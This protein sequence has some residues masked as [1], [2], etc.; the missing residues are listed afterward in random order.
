MKLMSKVIVLLCILSSTELVIAQTVNQGAWMIG[1]TAGFSSQKFDGV[2]ESQTIINITP[3][4]GY[5]IMDDLAIGARVNFLS[6]SFDGDTDSNF[7]FGPYARYY[8]TNPIFLQAGIDF[9]A[10]ALDLNSLLNDEGSSTLHF[11][12][13]YSWFLNNS[14]AIEPALYYD[15]Y[16]GDEDINDADYSRFGLNIGVQ[17][18][19]GRNSE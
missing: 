8:I 17:A 18:F 2:D 7:G 1:G 16:N 13:G 4:L 15:I 19:L 11:M 9:E 10:A 5:Y 12:V 14:I 3:N 6:V